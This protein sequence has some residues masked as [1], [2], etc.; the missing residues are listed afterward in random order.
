MTFSSGILITNEKLKALPHQKVDAPGGQ[1]GWGW[2]GEAGSLLIQDADSVHVCGQSLTIQPGLSRT[3]EKCPSQIGQNT[4]TVPQYSPS[5]QQ[6]GW[7]SPRSM[8]W[9]K[10]CLGRPAML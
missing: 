2:A 9:S 5:H 8:G 7:A 10:L 4:L 3:R 6:R 1:A